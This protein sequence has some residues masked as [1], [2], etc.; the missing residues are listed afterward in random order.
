MTVLCPS[1]ELSC[2][3]GDPYCQKHHIPLHSGMGLDDRQGWLL[4][5]QGL[6]YPDV[7]LERIVEAETHPAHMQQSHQ[8]RE[9]PVDGE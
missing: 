2:S 4:Q 3:G 6:R 1:A 7:F 5:A 8:A 9:A